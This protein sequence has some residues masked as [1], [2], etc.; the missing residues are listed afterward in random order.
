MST[1]DW[2]IDFGK[3]RNLIFQL[4]GTGNLALIMFPRK[5]GP[6][7]QILINIQMVLS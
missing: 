5:F 7:Q 1:K 2:Y 4:G 6:A 3:T